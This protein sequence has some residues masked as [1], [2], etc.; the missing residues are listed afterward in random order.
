MSAPSF[1][2]AHSDLTVAVTKPTFWAKATYALALGVGGFWLLGRLGR[3]AADAKA[4][5][6]LLAVVLF[7]VASLAAFELA[8]LPAGERVAAM[9][10]G[11]ARVCPTNILILSALAAPFVFFAA[12]RF[13]PTRPAGA[14]AATGLMTAGMVATLYGLHCPKHSAAFVAVWYTLGVALS[15][16]AGAVIGRF[17]FRW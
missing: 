9:M 7:A 13:A 6:I 15:T 5:P 17:V 10:G 16:A 14:G 11:S 3:P 8:S 2:S 12:R 4:P 1:P